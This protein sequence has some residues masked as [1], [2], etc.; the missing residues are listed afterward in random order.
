MEYIILIIGFVLLIKGADFFVE[1]SSSVAKQ[2]RVPSMIIGL[3]IVAMGTS[4]PECSVSITAALAHKN[5]LAISNAVGSNTFN[6]MVVCGACTLFCPLAVQKET[7]KKEFPFSIA[8]A[9]LLLGFGFTGMLVGHME[10]FVM[11]FLFACFLIWMIQSGLITVQRSL[12]AQQST[13]SIFFLPPRPLVFNSLN[14]SCTASPFFDAFSLF[15]LTSAFVYN[16]TS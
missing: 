8:A 6:L 5:G 10:G 13:P 16:F 14:S 4:L 7:L 3:T 15:A 11:L 9:L 2:L 1:G 12:V